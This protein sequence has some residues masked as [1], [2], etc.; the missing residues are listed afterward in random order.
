[1]KKVQGEKILRTVT[2]KRKGRNENDQTEFELGVGYVVDK[3]NRPTG[4]VRIRTEQIS[5]G[6]APVV[7]T[8]DLKTAEQFCTS[9]IDAIGFAEQT[10]ADQPRT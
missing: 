5:S 6:V 7:A 2:A 3:N 8:L 4:Y 10:L 9:L 1:M